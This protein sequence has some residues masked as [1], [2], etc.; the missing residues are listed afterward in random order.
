MSLSQKIIIS[1][2]LDFVTDGL[3]GLPDYPLIPRE[4]LE[5]VWDRSSAAQEKTP[6]KTHKK[7]HP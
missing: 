7:M 2:D 6:K 4:C 3:E 5:K 1:F